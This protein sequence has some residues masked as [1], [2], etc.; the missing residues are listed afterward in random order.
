MAEKEW[1]KDWFAD[2][3]YLTLYK[4]RNNDEASEAL[5]LIERTTSVDKTAAILDLACGAGR[6]SINLAKRGYNNITAIDL[7][8]TL[9]REAIKQAKCEAVKINFIQQDMRE[10]SGSYD[11]VINLFTSF[12]YFDS[13]EENGS[14][15]ERVANSLRKNGFFVLDF[16]NAN[17]LE[18][19]L[20]PHDKIVMNESGETVDLLREIRDGRVE[21]KIRISNN[22]GT[23][24]EFHESVRLFHLN[25][26]SK[27]FTDS[28]LHI[29]SIFGNYDGSPF[30]EGS[31][32]RLILVAQK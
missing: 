16:L 24:T 11:L 14:V 29:T 26:L 30:E 15:I 1:Y 2:E 8:P 31:S 4:N 6:H 5:D 3:R 23:A 7:S 27:M 18:K 12:G 10:I 20:I 32:P 17:L 13:D 22:D 9:I 28:R 25:E 19:N 21:K